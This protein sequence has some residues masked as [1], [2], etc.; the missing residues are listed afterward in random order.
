MSSLIDTI[1]N[2]A[3]WGH[4]S[5]YSPAPKNAKNCSYDTPAAIDTGRF[6][7]QRFK[8]DR[9]DIVDL[10][11]VLF[12]KTSFMNE[13]LSPRKNENEMI[14]PRKKVEVVEKRTDIKKRKRFEKRE[15]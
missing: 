10:L 5:S 14:S 3:G 13:I 7:E 4:S 6:K 8:K 9:V 2:W 12:S 1:Y 15:K 11:N